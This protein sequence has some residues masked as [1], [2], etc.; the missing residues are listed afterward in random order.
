MPA[1]GSRP[2]PRRRTAT[3]LECA[4]MI[5]IRAR[6]AAH[7]EALAPTPVGAFVPICRIIRFLSW[8]H[9]RNLA[10]LVRVR[11]ARVRVRGWLTEPAPT[12]APLQ[13]VAAAVVSG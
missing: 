6:M 4:D 10:T 8:R 3:E 12:L 2:T 1:L 7:A 5:R 13:S 9:F 11:A